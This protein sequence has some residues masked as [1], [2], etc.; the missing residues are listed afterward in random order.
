M[1]LHISDA[2]EEKLRKRGITQFHLLECFDN[3]AR[4]TLIDSREQHRTDPPTQWFI[5]ETDAGR[6]LKVVFIQL[7]GLD[8]AIRS[9]FDPNENEESYYLNKSRPSTPW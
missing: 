3:R 1:I 2:V 5:S 9:A 8:V 4:T 6:R 7:T